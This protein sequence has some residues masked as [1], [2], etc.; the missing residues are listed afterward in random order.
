MSN[1]ELEIN[2]KNNSN[3]VTI[4]KIN[5]LTREIILTSLLY[6][7]TKNGFCILSFDTNKEMLDGLV[8][9]GFIE[10]I[11]Y[12][13]EYTSLKPTILTLTKKSLL[14]IL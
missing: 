3:L 8:K 12:S 9:N 2:T 5:R 14:Q 11:T 1:F 4:Y 10:D 6:K 7:S 13:N